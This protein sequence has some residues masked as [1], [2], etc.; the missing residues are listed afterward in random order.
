MWQGLACCSSLS[1][2]PTSADSHRK[3]NPVQSKKQTLSV[4]PQT[5]WVRNRRNLGL[6]RCFHPSFPLK[7]VTLE[8]KG[9]LRTGA[10]GFAEGFQS[11]E[12]LGLTHQSDGLLVRR[13]WNLRKCGVWVWMFAKTILKTLKGHLWLWRKMPREKWKAQYDQWHTEQHFIFKWKQ[14]GRGWEHCRL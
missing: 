2:L 12:L 8:K 7:V 4:S 3:N 6:M 1:W 5:F 14:E 9:S 13:E 10:A 11:M